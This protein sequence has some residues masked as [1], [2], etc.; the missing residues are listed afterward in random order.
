LEHTC[1][2]LKVFLHFT[3]VPNEMNV[4]FFCVDIENGN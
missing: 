3:D 2:G 1:F 4:H